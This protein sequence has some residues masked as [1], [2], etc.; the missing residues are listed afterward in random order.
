M[1][2]TGGACVLAEVPISDRL[3]AVQTTTDDVVAVDTEF[4]RGHDAFHATTPALMG[5]A[6]AQR[7]AMAEGR[8]VLVGRR[9]TPPRTR[10][11]AVG[12]RPR[13]TL[14]PGRCSGPV[15]S[16]P[17]WLRRPRVT[18]RSMRCTRSARA[19]SS[20]L[21]F[22]SSGSCRPG[23]HRRG[24]QEGPLRVGPCA[25]RTLAG[26]PVRADHARRPLLRR[27]GQ[28]RQPPRCDRG[29]W[30]AAARS[31]S[32]DLPR[33]PTESGA[34]EAPHDP[35]SAGRARAL[36]ADGR[37]CSSPPAE[38]AGTLADDARGQPERFSPTDQP[39]RSRE[40][41]AQARGCRT[42]R[43]RQWGGNLRP[44]R[45]SPASVRRRARL[46]S[47]GGRPRRCVARG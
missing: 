45:G 1:T 10:V 11:D 12:G 6:P 41:R 19:R 37:A 22:P 26:G 28:H 13:G 17:P 44:L 23:D 35:S 4:D 20:S 24:A 36:S 46:P 9:A 47:R 5:L 29:T 2:S 27:A 25:L 34:G 16:S 21:M 32:R 30:F 39:D 8:C 40:R 31:S 15:R 14:D 18:R 33:R 42:R 43:R 3:G 38:S 7:D